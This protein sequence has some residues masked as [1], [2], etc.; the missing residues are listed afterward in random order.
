[1]RKVYTIVR[2]NDKDFT[3]RL[4]MRGIP[5][6]IELIEIACEVKDAPGGN[7]LFSGIVTK[8]DPENGVFK[9]RFPKEA[10]ANLTPNSRVYFDFMLTFPDGTVK[11][12]PVPPYEAL[13]IE[14]V[15][16]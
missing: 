6:N 3:V 16:D 12:Y 10:T 2:G 4:T 14:R 1:M 15:T 8:T 9:V 13:V 5:M 7:L 11:N